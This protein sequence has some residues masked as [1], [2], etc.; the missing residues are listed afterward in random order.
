MSAQ[1]SLF[2]GSDKRLK[3]RGHVPQT[4][5]E[6]GRDVN[7]DARMGAVLTWLEDVTLY[8]PAPTSAELARWRWVTQN[9]PGQVS[10]ECLLYVRR[11]LSDAVAKGFV[12]HAGTRQCW[13]TGKR[14]VTWKTRS[15]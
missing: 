13:V 1:P 15:R 12:E 7:R 3:K 14:C 5:V 2:D 11:G 4:S 9:Q 10:T 6:A 8:R